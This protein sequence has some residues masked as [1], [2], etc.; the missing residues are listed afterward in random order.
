MFSFSEHGVNTDLGGFIM[1][2]NLCSL[3]ARGQPRYSS[4]AAQMPEGITRQFS[5]G[6]PCLKSKQAAFA[7]FYDR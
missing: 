7:G 5:R 4:L 1:D 6:I 2:Y 3:I